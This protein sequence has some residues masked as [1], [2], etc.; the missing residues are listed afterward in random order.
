M[1]SRKGHIGTY[2]LL[3]GALA[4]VV[5]SLLYMVNF[6]N[7]F[8]NEE[9]QLNILLEDYIYRNDYVKEAFNVIVLESIVQSETS[10]DFIINFK[11]IAERRD[12]QEGTFGNF[13]AKIRNDEFS[14]EEVEDGQ[15]L[16]KMEGISFIV[17]NEAGEISRTF[18]LNKTFSI[19]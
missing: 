14:L 8:T 13:F 12:D 16:L 9:K 3:F 11:K 1:L 7:N 6:K 15:Y 17:K 5:Y 19:N 10:E 4:L 2:L 18:D